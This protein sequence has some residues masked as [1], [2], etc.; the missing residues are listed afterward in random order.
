MS[1]AKLNKMT[2]TTEGR[3]L[4]A[5]KSMTGRAPSMIHDFV[6]LFGFSPRVCCVV[7][8]ITSFDN[9]IHLCRLL[10]AL[11]F[12]KTY[13]KEAQLVA[14]AGCDRTTYRNK[15]WRML[16]SLKCSLKCSIEC[17]HTQV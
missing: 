8:N 7:W 14:L 15:V 6:T 2:L 1:G 9:D 4:L 3:V 12:L 5:A 17:R 11:N 13:A 10:L 16:K